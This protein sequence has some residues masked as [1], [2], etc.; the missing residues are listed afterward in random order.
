MKKYINIIRLS[1]ELH[2]CPA[3]HDTREQADRGL[4]EAL[5]NYR[6]QHLQF[7]TQPI[8]VEIADD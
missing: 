1:G 5:G 6:T 4:S 8:E 2:C 3:L 7:V